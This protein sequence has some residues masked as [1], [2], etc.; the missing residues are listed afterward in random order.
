[1]DL[2][3]LYRRALGML[4]AERASHLLAIASVAIGLVQLAQPILF[5][6]VVDTLSRGE[7]S[8]SAFQLYSAAMRTACGFWNSRWRTRSMCSR[9]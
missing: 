1:M 7:V 2:C 6:R 5:G 9:R 4:A 8:L 3:R